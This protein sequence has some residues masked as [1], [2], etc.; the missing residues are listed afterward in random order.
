VS[1]ASE[2]LHAR[3]AGAPPALLEAMVAA[4][5]MDGEVPEA[6]AAGAM[7]LYE[8]VLRGAGGRED[9]LPLLAADALLTHALEARAEM[10]ADGVG[11]FAE[12]WGGAGRI[13]VLATGAESTG[14]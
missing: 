3:L 2:W 4:L 1:A 13:G 7:S 6:L 14:G 8:Q 9:A 11:G 5:P 10:D 12:A